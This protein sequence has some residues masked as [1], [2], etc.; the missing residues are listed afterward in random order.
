MGIYCKVKVAL[1]GQQGSGGLEEL[2]IDVLIF[3][4]CQKKVMPY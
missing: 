1:F 3:I 2:L 4:C